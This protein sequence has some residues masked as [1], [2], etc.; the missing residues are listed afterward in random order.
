[1]ATTTF[2]LE[3]VKA[4]ASSVGEEFPGRLSS[5]V[6]Y[7][8]PCLVGEILNRL[9]VPVPDAYDGVRISRIPWVR[10]GDFT[11]TAQAIAFLQ[12]IQDRTDDGIVWGLAVSE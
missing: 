7:S 1:M 3:Q 2:D 6:W 4:V 9:E 8:A 12:R 10:I 11:F 5:D